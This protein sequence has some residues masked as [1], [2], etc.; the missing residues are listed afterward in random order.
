VEPV[1]VTL[2]AL[3]PVPEPHLRGPAPGARFFGGTGTG[4]WLHGVLQHLDFQRPEHALDGRPLADLLRDEG[5]RHGVADPAQHELATQNIG[6]W[7][8]T[9]FGAGL[10]D[11]PPELRL[12]RFLPHQ[13]ADEL[14]FYLRL[15]AG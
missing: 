12:R 3:P 13:R 1:T 4:S 9:P 2:N 7:L 15:G 6:P 8:D 11:V 14:E 5:L 10:P